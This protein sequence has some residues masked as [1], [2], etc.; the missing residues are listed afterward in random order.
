[1]DRNDQRT[2]LKRHKYQADPKSSKTIDEIDSFTRPDNL[3][4]FRDVMDAAAQAIEL[5]DEMKARK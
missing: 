2:G 4:Y 5:M 1:M 3:Q